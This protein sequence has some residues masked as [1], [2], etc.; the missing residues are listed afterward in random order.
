[1]IFFI[2]VLFKIL[3]LLNYIMCGIIGAINFNDSVSIV[4][5]GLKIIRNRG[6]DSSNFTKFENVIF[7]H[8]L[9]AIIDFVKQPIKNKKEMLVFNGEIY[10]WEELAK[11]NNLRVKNDSQLLIKLINKY[12]VENIEQIVEKIDGVFAFAYYSKTQKKLFIARD[13]I[14]EIPLVYYF[15]NNSFAFASEKKALML[16]TKNLN[17][18]KILVLDCK[19]KENL[20]IKFINRKIKKIK[21]KN[22]EAQLKEAILKSVKKRIPNNKFSLLLS[23][24]IDSYLIGQIIKKNTKNLNSYFSYVE[25]VGIPKDLEFAKISASDLKSKLIVKKVSLK[26]FEEEL[27]KIISLIESS[28]PIRVGV[29]STIYFATK[30]ISGRVVFSGLGADELFAG[31]FRFKNSTNINKDSYSY[32]LKLFENDLYYQNIVCMNNKKELRLPYLDKKVISL[33]LELNPKMKISSGR[34]KIFL[35]NL[36]EELGGNKLIFNREKKAAQYGSNFDKAISLLAKKNGFKSKALYLKSI[37]NSLENKNIQKNIS[38]GAL[39]STGKDSVYSI[40]LMKRKGHD[41]KCLIT[42]DSKNKD[43]FMFHTPTIKLAKKISIATKIPLIV[44]KT[45]GEKETELKD[46]KKAINLAIKK[47]KIEGLVNGALYSNYQRERI[48]NICENEGI[49]SFSPLWQMNQTQYLR[50]IIK[51]NF[52]VV[53]TKIACFGLDESFLGRVIDEKTI[54]ELSKL[55]KQYGVNVAGEGGE[56]ET[57]VIDAPFFKKKLEI[58]FDKIMQNEFTGEIKIKKLKLVKKD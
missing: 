4:K 53:I 29:A 6:V 5:N 46:L 14:G 26:K 41:I 21:T 3:F 16:N 12:R 8:N 24:G 32:I 28:D 44:V 30:N 51:E 52:K 23:G 48:E 1:M 11:E 9:H 22:Q 47:Y 56:Y 31:Y 42:I 13:I 49:R 15:D 10:N 40:N 37:Q 50:R 33:A 19:N 55:E 35:R 45:I 57:L 27:P 54:N 34:N 20:K 25:G 36:S 58:E 18:R 17:P 43:S 38:L 7:G 39:L 2:F